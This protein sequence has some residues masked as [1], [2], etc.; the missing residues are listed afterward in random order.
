MKTE[1]NSI[2]IAGAGQAAAAAAV[3]LRRVGY[4]GRITLVGDEQHLP[5]ER[6]QLSKEMLRLDV[7]PLQLS[8]SADA[9]AEFDIELLLGCPIVS[10]DA[11]AR[12]VSLEDGRQLDYDRLLIATGVRP[13]LLPCASDE[14]V[15]YLRTVEQ[16]EKL[17]DALLNKPSL[18]IVGGGVIGLE[19]A[20]AAVDHG[21]LVTLVEAAPR[22]M[23]R[24]LDADMAAHLG[25]L[26][27]QRGVTI[28][29]G[30]TVQ[31][32]AAD[33]TVSLSNNTE[34]KADS[35]LAGI[36]VLPNIEAFTDLGICDDAGIRVDEFGRTAIPDIYATGDVASQPCDDRHGRIET[37]AN[38]QEHAACVAR[39]L[40]DEPISCQRPVWF[41][42]D[43][44]TL[45]LQVIGDALAGRAVL[46]GDPQTGRFSQ[47]RIGDDGRLL[48]CV[49][50]NSPKDMA[51]ARRWV[52]DG[53]L[54]DGE[55]L[56]APGADLRACIR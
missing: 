40:I 48:G 16:A 46:R 1:I 3:E 36:G 17:R 27:R 13:R 6:P 43:Q 55:R 14:R 8:Q 54:L 37:W 45:N 35:I 29:H 42:S 21:C 23:S 9:F 31:S 2:V 44:G 47:F 20:S 10:A 41:W 51:M 5:Y 19:V 7:Q 50:W 56:A 18:V 39:N 52:R 28:I 38:A 12:V 11:V 34:I 32:I 30:A 53:T 33:G 15:T 4:E 22:L 25:D 24:S 26:H 49:S